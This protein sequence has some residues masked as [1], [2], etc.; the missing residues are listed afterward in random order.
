MKDGALFIEWTQSCI[1]AAI[2]SR[3]LRTLSAWFTQRVMFFASHL[4]VTDFIYQTFNVRFVE[5]NFKE[6]NSVFLER[7]LAFSVVWYVLVVCGARH[8]VT[9]DSYKAFEWT[10]VVWDNLGYNIYIYTVFIHTW[11]E[12]LIPLVNMIKE[13]CENKCALLILLIFYFF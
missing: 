11:S 9:R 5:I 4:R 2:R 1:Q 7:G 13:G 8:S 12:L 10:T 3:L 6:F